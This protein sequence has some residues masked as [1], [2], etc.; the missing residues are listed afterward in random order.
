MRGDWPL[1]AFTVLGQAAVGIDICVGTLLFLVGGPAGGGPDSGTRL[2]LV[3]AVLGLMAAAT[4]LSLFHL[5]HPVGAYRVLTNLA[6][7]WLSREI[8][9]EIG[10]VGITAL[11]G[12]CEWRRV[13]SVAFLKALFVLG[14][15]AGILFLVSMSRLY[16]LPAVPAW[17]RAWTPLSFL[18]T[19]LSLGALTAATLTGHWA[20]RSQPGRL[21]IALAFVFVS[22]EF[23]GSLLVTPV[24]GLVGYVPSSSL[25][26]RAP[27]R[28]RIHMFKLIVLAAGL[29]LLVAV[30]TT[31]QGSTSHYLGPNGFLAL[32]L[33]LVFVGQIT[34]RF[35]FYGLLAPLGR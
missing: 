10:F 1:V 31:E 17:N 13:G 8:L 19:S 22:M 4:A 2:T 23:A 33:A 16:M 5:H 32:A 18:L 35:L 12:F 20:G 29:G 25:R 24:F 7:S 6:S 11:V 27:D 30:A 9:F 3:L 28:H 21:F 26:P 14:G 15:L 34:G